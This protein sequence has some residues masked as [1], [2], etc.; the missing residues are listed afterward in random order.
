MLVVIY[1]AILSF[2]IMLIGSVLAYYSISLKYRKEVEAIS[3]GFIFGVA[4]LILLVKGYYKT[5]FLPLSLGILTVYIIEKFLAYCPMSKNYCVECK[6]LEMF[7]VKYIYPISF[8]IHTF[9]DGLILAISYL[10]NIGLPLYLAIITHKIPAG[11]VL[12][13]PLK[14]V[15]KQPL[16]IC[17]IISF[18]TVLGTILGLILLKNLPIK[19]LLSYSAGIFLGTFI[20]LY[21][22]MYHHKE[23]VILYIIIGYIIVGLIGMVR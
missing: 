18:G 5:F 12:L 17:S 4:T 20:T 7:K 23:D 8:F 2:F 14:W 16:L 19:P 10:G 1:I 13:S 21:P 9:I 3:L 6:N 15:Y 11:F 22:H